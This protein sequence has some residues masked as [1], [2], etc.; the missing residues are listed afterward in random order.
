MKKLLILAASAALAFGMNSAS[1]DTAGLVTYQPSVPTLWA[2]DTPVT[3]QRLIMVQKEP[4]Y[5]H[6]GPIDGMTPTGRYTEVQPRTYV[7]DPKPL[8]ATNM[9]APAYLADCSEVG[10][11]WETSTGCGPSTG[12]RISP[13]IRVIFGDAK[14]HEQPAY[15]GWNTPVVLVT[16]R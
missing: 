2:I 6:I 3:G 8:T 13:N 5:V 9:V 4:E 12:S 1:A 7:V 14:K 11:T 10:H 15:N 16:T